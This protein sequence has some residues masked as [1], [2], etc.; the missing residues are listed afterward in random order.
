MVL[1]G[2][3]SMSQQVTAVCRSCFY[4]LRQLKSVKSSLYIDRL[5]IL[6][7]RLLFTVCMIL[8]LC[9]GW[10]GQSLSSET[11]VCAEHGCSYGVW[12]APKVNTSPQF[13]KIYTASLKKADLNPADV[14]SYRPTSNLSVV[15]KLL[16]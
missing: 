16:E 5:S 12:S 9:A 1:D 10:S 8:Q 11:S 14:K 15:S 3:L 4:K 7:Y 13:L 2:Q 6:L